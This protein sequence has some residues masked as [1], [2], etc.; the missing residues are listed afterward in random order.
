MS[1]YTYYNAAYLPDVVGQHNGGA[2]CWFNSMIQVVWGLPSVAQTLIENE[3]SYANNAFARHYLGLMKAATSR[4][5]KKPLT[6]NSA[7]ELFASYQRRLKQLNIGLKIGNGQECA[8]EGLCYFINALGPTIESLFNNVYEMKVVCPSCNKPTSV[9]RDKSCVVTI[10]DRTVFTTQQ[11]FCNHLHY[12]A[13]PLVCWKCECGATSTGITRTET[14]KSLREI[15]IVVFDKFSVKEMR[16]F[17]QELSFPKIGGGHMKYELK[18]KIEHIGNSS[19]G[20]YYAHTK[21]DKWYCVNDMG[22]SPGNGDP[23]PTTFM[24]AYHL[25]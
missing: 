6:N 8:N 3:S 14:L 16:W 4:I 2:T 25:V 23:T 10:S 13:N 1:E 7:I 5:E 21:R 17:P 24:A 18:G 20:H 12:R 9:V 19:G 22:V 11:Q 15:I